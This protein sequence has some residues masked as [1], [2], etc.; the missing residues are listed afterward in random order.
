MIG[1]RLPARGVPVEQTRLAAAGPR[2][3]PAGTPAV[4]LLA[5]YLRA[6][7]DGPLL[8]S[9]PLTAAIVQ[10]VA[11]LIALSLEPAGIAAGGEGV[12]A[13]RLA[14]IKSDIDRDLTD[15]SLCV[16]TLAARH[17]ISGRY[18]HKLFER[19]ATTYS[20]FVLERRLIRAHRLLTQPRSAARTVSSIAHD[21]GFGDLSYFNRTFRRRYDAT[22]TEVRRAGAG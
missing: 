12:R 16:A 7:L 5:R 22:P 17:G 14:A 13:A 19:E 15:P 20:Q 21:S 4:R 6:A 2:R 3:L 18:L 9:P 11:E 8:T 1:I 10:H